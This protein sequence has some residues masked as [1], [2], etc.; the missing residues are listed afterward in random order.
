MTSTTLS[1][2]PVGR[3]GATSRLFHRKRPDAQ[4]APSPD[5]PARSPLRFA[6]E[7]AAQ[8]EYYVSYAWGDDTPEGR[9]RE[10]IVDRLC[11]AAAESGLSIIRD[12]TTLGVGDRISKF[13][14]RLGRGSRVFVVLSE[15]YLTS[16]YCMFELSEVWRN[17]REDDAE[18]LSHVR[19]YTLPGTRIWTARDRA[20]HALHWKHEYDALAAMVR[21][22]GDEILGEKGERE[23]RRMKKFSRQIGDML[24]TVADILQPRDFEELKKCG[25]S[26]VSPTASP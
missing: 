18:F 7:P 8:P 1:L 26:D 9:E 19:V 17:C 13:M 23:Y 22:H 16:P 3:P 14:G 10:A 2:T 4:P 5:E 21:E 6:P 25:F 12:K 11:A 24:A 15:K 20:Q